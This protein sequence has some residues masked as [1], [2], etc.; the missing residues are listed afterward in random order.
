MPTDPMKPTPETVTPASAASDEM[1]AMEAKIKEVEKMSPTPTEV[2]PTDTVMG[3][4]EALNQA[5]GFL[6]DGQAAPVDVPKMGRIGG[7]KAPLPG[8]V[9]ALLMAL[10]AALSEVASGKPDLQGM[11]FDPMVDATTK[12]GIQAMT[13]KL[14]DAARSEPLKAAIQA[15]DPGTR[16]PAPVST[17]GGMGAEDEPSAEEPKA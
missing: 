11:V 6:S 16:S 17:P 2:I 10:A 3:L 1:A 8:P 7:T 15:A 9:F 13:A 14:L 4:V 5:T 12:A